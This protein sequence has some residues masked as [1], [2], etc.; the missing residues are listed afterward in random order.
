MPLQMRLCVILLLPLALF[1]AP[2]TAQ[3]PPKPNIVFVLMD[4][5][6]WDCMS[7]AGHPFIRTPNLDRLANEGAMFNNFFVSIPLCSPS[8]SSFLTGRYAHATGITDNTDHSPQ[9]HELITWPRLLHDQGG[10]ET[11]FLGKW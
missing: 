6:R 9:S 7:C 3:Q 2:V 11:A 10:Y 1:A 5:M 8:R 4:D